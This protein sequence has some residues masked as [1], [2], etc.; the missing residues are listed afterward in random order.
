[1]EG[2]AACLCAGLKEPVGSETDD[3]GEDGAGSLPMLRAALD[4]RGP[5][6]ISVE[7]E[8]AG[9]GVG[10]QEEEGWTSSP[11]PLFLSEFKEAHH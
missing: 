6:N 3:T 7:G 4:R 8:D 11:M 2:I 1:M 5:T 10:V 9:A